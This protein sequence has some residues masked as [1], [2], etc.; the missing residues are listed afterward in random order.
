MEPS[1]QRLALERA[2]QQHTEWGAADRADQYVAA[3]PEL[4]E[5][6]RRRQAAA[7]EVTP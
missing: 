7:R 4:V 6:A 3:H 1:D 2:D 5:A